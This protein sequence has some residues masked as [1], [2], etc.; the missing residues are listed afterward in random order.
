MLVLLTAVCLPGGAQGTLPYETGFEAGEGFT[1]GDYT[2]GP[3]DTSNIWAVEEGTAAVQGFDIFEGLQSL[4]VQASSSVNSEPTGTEDS[5]VIWLQAAY[6]TEPQSEDP[7]VE[8]LS[9]PSSAL[10]YFNSTDGIRVYDG[11][12]N[13]PVW[14]PI[15]YPVDGDTWYTIAIKLDFD[16]Q[17]WDIYVDDGLKWANIGF[18]DNIQQFTGFRCRSGD[19]ASGYLD[20]FYVGEEPPENVSLP[21]T[22]TPTPTV[23][24]TPTPTVTPTA[25]PA[26]AYDGLHFLP[27]SI[28]WNRTADEFDPGTDEETSFNFLNT[29]SDDEEIDSLDLIEYIKKFNDR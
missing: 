8:Q 5:R 23:T 7:D 26:F 22:Q 13:P 28:Y 19:A 16:A 11:A 18:K 24:F 17:R 1:A 4:E 6:R 14:V 27:Y 3:I 9:E 10:M 25:T 29:F 20:M 12:R 2:L 21:A 15:Q